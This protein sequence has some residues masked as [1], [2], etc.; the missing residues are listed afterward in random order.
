LSQLLDAALEQLL[1]GAKIRQFVGAGGRKTRQQRY[2]GG[3][4]ANCS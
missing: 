4:A 3:Q 1:I 2:R